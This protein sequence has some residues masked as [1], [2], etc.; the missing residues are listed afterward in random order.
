MAFEALRET[1]PGMAGMLE[2]VIGRG[3]L[4]Q[5]L[6]FSGH[7]GSSRMTAALDLAFLLTGESDK[8]SY[9]SS[10]RIS[11]FL[12]RPLRVELMAASAL[13]SRQRNDRSRRFY[14]ECVRK[15]LMQYHQSI[16]ELHKEASGVKGI[17]RNDRTDGDRSVTAVASLIDERLMQ[18]EEDREYS[19]SEI[20]SAIGEI[21][22][23]LT[24]AVINVGKK[25][26]G[27]T[28][29]EIR[30]TQ[31]W[32]QEGLDE[33]VVIFENAEDYTE[34]AKNSLL[35]LL[36]E[37]P[38]HSH[39]ILVSKSP[40]RLLETILS[41]CRKFSFPE[42]S[43]ERISQFIGKRF[44]IYGNYDSFDQFFFE[45]GADENG[46]KAMEG[47]LDLYFNALSERR[48]LPLSQEEEMFSSLER[49]AGYEY[50]SSSLL[51]RLGKVLRSGRME[52][53]KAKKLYAALSEGI[54]RSQT[55]NMPMRLALDLVLRE[56]SDVN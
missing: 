22:G 42:L 54:S 19:E 16:S 37:P 47:Y 1:Q 6:L 31:S 28:I 7:S 23:Y 35:K 2:D 32:L 56:V 8:R 51:S 9:L 40:S 36:E 46:K 17:A 21:D 18:I 48:M 13:F 4:P 49:M 27:A 38:L 45:E 14:I 39:L 20:E 50:F 52:S 30:A 15:V 12:S 10:Q 44:S 34:G 29:E 26:A 25:T 41:R 53:G 24:D 5:T 33:K 55:Y 3:M 43:P 11:L